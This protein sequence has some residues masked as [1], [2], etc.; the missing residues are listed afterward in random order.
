MIP[1]SVINI[2]YQYISELTRERWV[3][4]IT[5]H[6][7]IDNKL[8]MYWSELPK[9]TKNVKNRSLEPIVVKR[10]FFNGDEDDDVNNNNVLFLEHL[11]QYK[12]HKVCLMLMNEFRFRENQS[13]V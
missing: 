8:S 11:E 1:Y 10:I 9:I 2:I 3:G 6:E 13:Y 7:K 5:D 12:K 4:R